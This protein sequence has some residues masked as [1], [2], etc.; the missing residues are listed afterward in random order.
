MAQIIGEPFDSRLIKHARPCLVEA[1]R[2]VK[3]SKLTLTKAGYPKL[4]FPARSEAAY[5]K[6]FDKFENCLRRHRPKGK[7]PCSGIRT[8][9]ARDACHAKL[10]A[11][12]KAEL[13]KL[14]KKY[15][16][17]SRRKF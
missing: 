11:A 12:A 13:A 15:G 17:S 3:S 14:K 6:V 16:G 2:A 9:K 1:S 7:K 10:D 8:K 4:T 5:Y